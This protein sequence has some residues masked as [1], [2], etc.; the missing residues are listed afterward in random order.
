[1][2][3]ASG[4][5]PLARTPRLALAIA[6]CFVL[7][8]LA[9]ATA[10]ALAV[11]PA[12]AT[13]ANRVFTLGGTAVGDVTL[14]TSFSD[15]T[16]TA[17]ATPTAL[18][19]ALGNAYRVR[20]CVVYKAPQSPPASECQEAEVRPS[21]LNVVTGV[22]V[23]GAGMTVERPAGGS[24]AATIAAMVLVDVHRPDGSYEPNASSWPAEGLPAAG[25][26]VPATDA[27]S[28][29]ILPPQGIALPGVRG[30]GINTG[31]Q[32]SIC[33]EDQVAPSPSAGSTTALGELPFAYEVGEPA[34]GRAARGAMIVL[35]GG[36]WSSVGRAKLS[37]TRADAQRWQARGWRTINATYRACATS[38]D[39]VLRLYDRVRTTYGAATPI[40]AFGRSAGGHL[41][42]LLAARRSQ[43]ACVVAEAGIADFTTLADQA[44][45][46]GTAGPATIANLA[47]AAFGADRLAQ[48]SAGTSAVRARVLYAIG[49]ADPLIPF[50]QATDFAAAQRR[51]DPTAYVDTLRLASGDQSFEHALVSAAALQQFHDREQALVAPLAIGDVTVPARARLRTVRASGLRVR[52]SCASRCAVSARLELGAAAAKRLGIARVAGRGTARRAAR[53]R[54][55]LTVRLGAAARRRIGPVTARVISDVT[56]GGERR[57]QTAP[58]VLRRP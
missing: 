14:R 48:V 42:L 23:P 57:R 8:A 32:D 53:G 39:D 36:G 19:L 15:A 52:F 34:G 27:T 40:C 50:Q 54:G 29:P 49:A 1:M 35:H 56:A 3:V 4:R 41:A 21:V 2:T 20:T 33:R 22:P 47:T 16:A 17:T 43:L 18:K 6:A 55:T 38:V 7:L 44:A 12:S 37:V 11:A 9:L 5:S 58:V 31:A 24:P 45:A 28:G 10:P 25:A 26:V 13:V 46:D 30:G 51:R